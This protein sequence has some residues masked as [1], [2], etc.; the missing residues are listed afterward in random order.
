MEKTQTRQGGTLMELQLHPKD[1]EIISF[2]ASKY[3][4]SNEELF[5]HIMLAQIGMLVDEIN[6]MKKYSSPWLTKNTDMNEWPFSDGLDGDEIYE[7][8]IKEKKSVEST[9]KIELSQMP[10]LASLN[11]ESS[12]NRIAE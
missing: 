9:E 12:L 1:V 3:G 6:F 7:D 11:Q 8:F 2:L 4:V 5:N 10:L